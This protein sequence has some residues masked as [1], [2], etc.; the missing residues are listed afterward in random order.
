MDTT[1]KNGGLTTA[2][3]PAEAPAGRED[4]D[5]GRVMP[6][7]RLRCRRCGSCE[8][9]LTVRLACRVCGYSVPVALR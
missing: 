5:S 1:K 6:V 3:Q 8:F 7:Y 4:E 2:S 9:D